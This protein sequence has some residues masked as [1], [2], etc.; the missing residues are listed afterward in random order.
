LRGRIQR[1]EK[2]AVGKHFKKKTHKLGA[3]N[4][5]N[6]SRQGEHLG[7]NDAPSEMKALKGR[8]NTSGTKRE[9][10]R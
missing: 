3:G 4:T 10:E 7:E 6:G 9:R 8:L 5:G 1:K 2:R